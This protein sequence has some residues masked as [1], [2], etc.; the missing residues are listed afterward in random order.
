MMDPFG[1]L[2]EQLGDLT[3]TLD[4]PGTDLKAMLDVLSDDLT[5]AVP[6]YLGLTLTLHLDDGPV[7]LTTV[8]ADLALGA[9]AWIEFPLATL[10]SADP[11]STLVCYARRPGSFVALATALNNQ[12]PASP[13]CVS[14]VNLYWMAAET[15]LVLRPGGQ[16]M[17]DSPVPGAAPV[18]PAGISGLDSLTVINRAIGVLISG[19]LGP[20][21][22]HSEL[23]RR[24][25]VD[26]CALPEVAEAVVS[27]TNLP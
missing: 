10:A 9:G 4:D 25:A 8:D 21:Q 15:G 13:G 11:A 12:A 26:G 2:T 3:I 6:S 20:A 23:L 5:A 7:T 1:L 14:A 27:G 16:H 17:L 24:A 22:A 19:G 18:Q